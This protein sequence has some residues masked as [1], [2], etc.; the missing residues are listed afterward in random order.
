MS[1]EQ[2]VFYVFVPQINTR[3]YSYEV[4]QI[5]LP[6]HHMNNICTYRHVNTE[7]ASILD[8]ELQKTMECSEQS[9]SGKIIPISYSILMLLILK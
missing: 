7:T 2:Y 5:G 6:I 8:K 9:F 3:I 4:S 1:E